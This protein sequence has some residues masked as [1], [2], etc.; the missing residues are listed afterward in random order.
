MMHTGSMAGGGDKAVIGEVSFPY[1]VKWVEMAVRARAER[2]MRDFPVSSSQLLA[3]VMLEGRVEATAAE[4]A[5]MMR[6]TPQAM[7]TLIAP[8]RD[9]GYLSRRSD[10]RHGRRLLLRLTDRGRV[11]LDRARELAPSIEDALLEGFTQAERE[12]LKHLLSRIAVRFD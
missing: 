3:L 7:T 6:I 5:R 12:T 9:E 10:E 2:E 8:L 4:L 11:V 1:L